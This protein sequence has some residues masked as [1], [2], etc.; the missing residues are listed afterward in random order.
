M[1][2]CRALVA[3]PTVALF[4]LAACTSS[5]S[6]AGT[7]STGGSTTFSPTTTAGASTSAAA[8]STSGLGAVTTVP[9][10]TTAAGGTCAGAGGIPATAD[11]GDTIT[12]DIDGD[13][14]ADTITEYSL[15][16]VPHVHS[17]LATGGQSDVEVPIGAADHVSISFEDF[18]YSL[19]A[20]TKPPVAVLAI[21][22][23]QAGTAVYTFLTNTPQYCIQPWHDA[24][25]T[26][27]VGRLSMQ[28]PYEGLSCEIAAGHRF[29]AVNEAVPDAAGNLTV[30]Q[31]VFH[32]NFT[33]IEFDAPL[34]SFTVPDTPAN[35]KQYG[36]LFDCDHAPVIP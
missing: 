32:H 34:P 31:T 27:W 18:D 2:H 13:L 20:T 35:E 26:M 8:T 36:D 33:R 17:R 4:A 19:G 16:G 5:S 3:L 29:N 22:A 28:G 11:V 7:G 6:G 12:G 30:V 1:S 25:A 24:S 10:I 14:V 15:D 9:T 21:G 23:T